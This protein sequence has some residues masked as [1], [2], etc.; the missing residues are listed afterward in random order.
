MTEE[1]THLQKQISQAQSGAGRAR[2]PAAVRQAT[3]EL[4]GRWRG[5]GKTRASLADTLGIDG[6]VLAGWEKRMRGSEPRKVKEVT[7][8]DAAPVASAP[9]PAA[10]VV[11]PNGVRIEVLTSA[12]ALELARALA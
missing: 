6:S 8:V 3:L 5:S 1:I 10:V 2:Y 7:V 9:E 11:F 4:L 12:M